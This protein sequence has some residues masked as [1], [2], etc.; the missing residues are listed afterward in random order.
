YGIFF[1]D[2]QG[3]TKISVAEKTGAAVIDGYGTLFWLAP[4]TTTYHSDT[5]SYEIDTTLYHYES[6][7]VLKPIEKK[8]PPITG[9]AVTT[10]HVRFSL[11][12]KET[13]DNGVDAS[14]ND[15]V[16]TL[17]SAGSY[18]AEL[19]GKGVIP[20]AVRNSELSG[21]SSVVILP[22]SRVTQSYLLSDKTQTYAVSGTKIFFQNRA[23][24]DTDATPV[25]EL[26]PTARRLLEQ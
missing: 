17:T 2:H 7:L 6:G 9:A 22:K 5:D 14:Y 26:S 10:P 12:K 25:K 19:I 15:G 23:I 24:Q 16:W 3:T 21:H 20:Y 1:I 8:I 13:P 18:D 11:Q 4:G